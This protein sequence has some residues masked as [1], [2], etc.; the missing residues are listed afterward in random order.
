MKKTR[1]K[2]FQT[3]IKINKI[4]SKRNRFRQSTKESMMSICVLMCVECDCCIYMDS[5]RRTIHDG[6]MVTIS[7]FNRI[8]SISTDIHKEKKEKTNGLTVPIIKSTKCG[9]LKWM[10]VFVMDIS[11]AAS[12]DSIRSIDG[13]TFVLFLFWNFEIV[14]C[15]II[16]IYDCHHNMHDLQIII[17]TFERWMLNILIIYSFRWTRLSEHI[18]R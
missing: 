8:H 14:E 12:K 7:W 17:I 15:K 1:K 5:G 10:I 3:I 18:Y 11:V 9:Y 2:V 16:W 13:L 4:L 6:S